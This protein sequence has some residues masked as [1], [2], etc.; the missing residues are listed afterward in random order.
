MSEC[1]KAMCKTWCDLKRKEENRT[2][3]SS[4]CLVRPQRGFTR[5]HQTMGMLGEEVQMDVGFAGSDKKC[6]MGT[7]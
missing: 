3:A 4:V 2:E 5:R 1:Y 7:I 6:I